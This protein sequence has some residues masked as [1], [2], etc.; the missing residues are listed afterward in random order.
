MT[1]VRTGA[2]DADVPE[3]IAAALDGAF[4]YAWVGRAF[5][6][7]LTLGWY[8]L[9]SW[10]RPPHVPSGARAFSYHR[11]S[12]LVALL[13]AVI[14]AAVVELFVVHLVVHALR[15]RVA[16]ALSAVSAVGVVWLVGLVRAIVL[17]PVLVTARGVTVRNGA[18]WTLD[19]PFAALERVET[20]RVAAPARRAPGL[21]RV[22]GNGRPSALLALREPLVAQGPYGRTKT[23]TTVAMT[24][25]DPAG[26][27]ASLSG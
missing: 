16:W 1:A 7:E 20:G 11:K 26:F 21:L 12:G 24:L 25:D 4:P 5:A 13:S 8:A 22:G 9:L 19:V 18:L 23:V 27:A 10:R 6:T 3:R 14:G 2:V 15:P 17:R